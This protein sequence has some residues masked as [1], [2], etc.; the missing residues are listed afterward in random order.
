MKKLI[1]ST[2]LIFLVI[3]CAK[4]SVIQPVATS[5]SMFD[6]AIIYKGETIKIADVSPGGEEFRVFEQG[7]TSVVPVSA[8]QEDTTKRANVFC[9]GIGKAM[10]PLRE[11]TSKPPHIL[12]NF[13]RAELVFECID[14]P[15]NKSDKYTQL[16]NLLS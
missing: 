8:L 16:I 15:D 9:N 1:A 2:I 10:K 3:G 12:G 13:P 4:T 6:S 7:A 5:Q 11:S 14:K